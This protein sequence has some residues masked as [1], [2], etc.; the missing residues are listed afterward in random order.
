MYIPK[1]TIIKLAMVLVI[2]GVFIYG[3]TLNN[4]MFW[5]DYDGIVNNLYIRSWQYLPNYFTENLTAGAG[6]TNNYWRPLLL[7]SYSIDYKIGGLNVFCFHLQNILW[8][9]LASISLLFLARKLSMGMLASFLT[10]LFFLIHPLQTEAVAY[11]SGRADP[12][13]AALMFLS[14]IFFIKTVN[15]FHRSFYALSLAFFILALLTKE[16]SVI[17]IPILISFLF[18]MRKENAYFFKKYI[19]TV[20]FIIIGGIFS[21]IRIF[22]LHFA[23][24]FV[25]DIGHNILTLDIYHKIIIYI[26][27]IVIYTKLI[28]YPS[29]LHMMRTIECSS[30]VTDMYVLSGLAILVWIG[31]ISF[32]FFKYNPGL[33]F[34][35]TWAVIAIT[36]TIYTLTIQGYVYE[37]WLYPVLPGVFIAIF[38]WLDKL[39]VLIKNK[40]FVKIVYGIIII[41]V[42]ILSIKTID[43]NNDWKNPVTFYEKNIKAG[44]EASI[45]YVNLG[46]AYAN[47]FKYEQAVDMYEKAI[48]KNDKIVQ[49]R[50]NLGNVYRL[51]NLEEQALDEYKKAIEIDPL[52]FSAYKNSVVIYINQNQ[53]DRAISMIENYIQISPFDLKALQSMAIIYYQ[54]GD[55]VEA[56]KYIH[57]ILKIEPDNDWAKA[58]L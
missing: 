30:V 53:Y 44:S 23:S 20:P 57:K 49:P 16:R 4:Q 1:F 19:L 2:V 10:A 21:I 12:M 11:V 29:D 22:I 45:M 46:V 40:F 37:H 50:Y 8:H 9:I 31:W 33:V 15:S 36:P 27:T 13:H 52:F 18:L 26:K 56:K 58:L 32:K 25:P 5:D 28:V 38:S 42:I 39:T 51:M 3:N 35:I 14:F 54:K 17:L 47:E 41:V 55:K 48:D 24:Y 7:L 43:R 6:I 34:G